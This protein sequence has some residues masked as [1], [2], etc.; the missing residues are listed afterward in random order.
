MVNGL[1]ELL[2]CQLEDLREM[3]IEHDG[4]ADEDLNHAPNASTT[5]ITGT[6]GNGHGT[7]LNN[8]INPRR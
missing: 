7:S 1:R 3:V 8:D 4:V 2:L 6:G 5:A